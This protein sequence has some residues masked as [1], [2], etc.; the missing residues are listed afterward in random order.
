MLNCRRTPLTVLLSS[1]EQLHLMRKSRPA[2]APRHSL[3]RRPLSP[4]PSLSPDA[5]SPL[6]PPSLHAAL[7]RS[8]R[9]TYLDLG[10][11]VKFSDVAGLGEIRRELEEVVDFFQAADKYRRRGSR[12][13][14]GI[15]LCGE[16]GCGKTLLAKAVAGEAGVNFFSISAS[17]FVEIFVG[18]GASRVRALYNEAR[19]NA[20][21]VV[22]IDELDAVGRQRGL[23]EG[24]GG[25]ERDATLNQVRGGG[26]RGE[27]GEGGVTTGLPLRESC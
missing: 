5:P 16:P 2:V 23:T 1:V 17:Q 6:P 18:V 13:P 22:F 4:C 12:I 10:A 27:G 11:E 9:P 19:E 20:P 14:S 25:Q 3:F 24:S 21:A 7:Q 15:L 26:K 8:R